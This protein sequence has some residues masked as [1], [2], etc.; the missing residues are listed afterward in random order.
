MARVTIPNVDF[1]KI[2]AEY[3]GFWV[4][5]KLGKEDQP[6]AQADSPQ[7]AMRL[8]RIDPADSNYV[9]TQVPETPTA[10]RMAIPVRP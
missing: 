5:V 8:S 6:L 1:T 3:G 2:P 4:V 7:E 10:A 9:L